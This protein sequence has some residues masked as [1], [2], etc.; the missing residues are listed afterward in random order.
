MATESLNEILFAIFVALQF[1]DAATTIK[2]L[3]G[4]GK[5]LNPVMRWLFSKLGT[6]NGLAVMKTAIILMFYTVIDVIPI[7]LYLSM[8]GLYSFVVAHNLRQLYK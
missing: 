2:I 4:G 7:W 6:I 8:I 3:D 1:A 5:E